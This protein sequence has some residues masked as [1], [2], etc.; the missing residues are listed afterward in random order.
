RSGNCASSAVSDEL[1]PPRSINAS[2]LVSM[3]ACRSDQSQSFTSSESDDGSS[4][5]PSRKRRRLR[6]TGSQAATMADPP[7]A[8]IRSATQRARVVLP[9]FPRPQKNQTLRRPVRSIASGLVTETAVA[10]V[11]GSALGTG[12]VAD[13]AAGRKGI[14]DGRGGV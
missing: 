14:T 8:S 4:A 11:G 2:L 10:A 12:T 5:T 9:V 13:R 6:L 1:P 7:R 3:A